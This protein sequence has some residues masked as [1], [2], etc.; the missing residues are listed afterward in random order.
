MQSITFHLIP[1]THHYNDLWQE[2]PTG[3]SNNP[4]QYLLVTLCF[5][6]VVTQESTGFIIM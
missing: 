2:F 6:S 1:V 5:Y 3:G 4:V